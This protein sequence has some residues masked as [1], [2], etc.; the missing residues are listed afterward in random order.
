MQRENINWEWQP[1]GNLSLW[2]VADAVK[3]HPTTHEEIFF[4]Q[5]TASHCSYYQTMPMVKLLYCKRKLKN[6]FLILEVS[7]MAAFLAINS[8]TILYW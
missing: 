8:K 4:N 6:K 5:A 3:K 1:N 7:N 2:N